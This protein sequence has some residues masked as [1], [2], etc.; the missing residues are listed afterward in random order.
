MKNLRKLMIMALV[1]TTLLS[2]FPIYVGATEAVED[3]MVGYY[4]VSRHHRDE[5]EIFYRIDGEEHYL[6]TVKGEMDKDYIFVSQEEVPEECEAVIGIFPN[7]E[8]TH[9]RVTIYEVQKTYPQLEYCIFQVGAGSIRYN[10]ISLAG[11]SQEV[12]CEVE[13]VGTTIN[14]F[15]VYAPKELL[16]MTIVY[17][18]NGLELPH[19]GFA[20]LTN[21]ATAKERTSVEGEPYF[22]FEVHQ[23]KED[24]TSGGG[25]MFGLY[26]MMYPERRIVPAELAAERAA[27]EAAQLA[28]QE[29]L[30]K[31][32][33]PVGEEVMLR[34]KVR[35]EL[36]NDPELQDLAEGSII[37][38]GGEVQGVRIND[39]AFT[40]FLPSGEEFYFSVKNADWEPI[41]E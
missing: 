23:R 27:E 21:E 11:E 32:L 5:V 19:E 38:E 8:T 29:A 1:L 6:K 40:P 7:S 16:S 33:P 28:E 22:N 41:S 25:S 18:Y 39:V 2:T 35:C 24:L 14:S 37:G 17:P 34:I 20:D 36:Y 10:Y 4:F 3:S 31:S 9:F 12:F 15:T 30:L 13:V 26:L